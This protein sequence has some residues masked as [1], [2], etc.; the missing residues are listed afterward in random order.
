LA[1]LLTVVTTCQAALIR[2]DR[3]ALA[4][5]ADATAT[6]ARALAQTARRHPT[7]PTVTPARVTKPAPPDMAAPAG[8]VTSTPSQVSRPAR[9]GTSATPTTAGAPSNPPDPPERPAPRQPLEDLGDG[10]QLQPPPDQ[11]STSWHLFLH[12]TDIGYIERTTTATG[13]THRWKA[14]TATSLVIT[15]AAGP[16]GVYRTKRDALIQ[17]AAHHQTSTESRTRTQRR[18]PH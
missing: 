12:G 1:D 5:A 13:R 11:Q 17:V 15:N 16:N 8:P 6:A 2:G 4:A 7:P 10:Y 3:H 18:L 9:T 14:Y